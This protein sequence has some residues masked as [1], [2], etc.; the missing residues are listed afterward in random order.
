MEVVHR[1]ARRVGCGELCSFTF[2]LRRKYSVSTAK[3]QM[4]MPLPATDVQTPPATPVAKSATA[5]PLRTGTAA[6]KGLLL[7][8]LL[9]LQPAQSP[10]PLPPPRR[11]PRSHRLQHLISPSRHTPGQ[12]G[13]STTRTTRRLGAWFRRKSAKAKAPQSAEK[14]LA[15]ARVQF[16]H[17]GDGQR[18]K[19]CTYSS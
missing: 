6:V 5:F 4:S 15:C 3:V 19:G 9:L 10:P 13:G 2:S 18:H 11:P 8:L 12:W 7:L 17:G 14:Y 16:T 1:Q